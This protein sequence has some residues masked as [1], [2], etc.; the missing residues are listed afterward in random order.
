MENLKPSNANL[1]MNFYS[2]DAK[3]AELPNE[4]QYDFLLERNKNYMH[5]TAL[6]FFGKVIT[7]EELHTRIDE[8]ARALYKKGVREFDI[9]ATSTANTPEAIYL[10]YAIN[11]LGAINTP[12]SPI[13]NEYKTKQ[14]L[15]IVKP[16][17]YVGIE[18]VYGMFKKASEGIN[19]MSL[20]YP[21]VESMD[22][23]LIKIL[24]G[25]KQLAN[26]NR[27]L[28]GDDQLMKIIK[29][30]KDSE[31]VFPEYSKGKLSHIIFTGGSSGTHKGV[32]LDD[33]GLNCVVRALDYV[34]P[35]N[36]GEKFMGNLPQFMAFGKM[37]MHYALCKSMQVDLTLKAMPQ[38]FKEELFRL[39]PQGVFAGPV[40]WEHFVNDVFKEITNEDQKI[41]FSLNNTKDYKEYLEN[42]KDILKKSDK[43]KYDM[44]WLHVAV[45]G[46][47]QLKFLTEKVVTATLNEFNVKDPSIYNGLGMTEMWAPVSVKMGSRSSE[48]TIGPMMP[49]T[50]QMIVDPITYEELGFDEVGLLLVS[51]PGMMQGYYNNPEESSKVFIEKEGTRWLNS[52]DMAKVLPNGELVY[53]DRLKRSFVCGVENVYP[54]QIENMLSEIPEIRESIV[55]KIPNNELQYVP[56]YH[57]SLREK[58]DIEE[59]KRKIDNMIQKT[60]GD[61]NVAR[62]YEFYDEPL[63]RT[64]NGKLDPK[65]LQ[66]K[67]YESMKLKTRKLEN[68]SNQ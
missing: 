45:S 47:E 10:D 54:Q 32:M 23:Q 65:P 62:Y 31:A 68:K 42:L 20:S 56:K 34:L 33:N 26:H 53:I 64:A 66:Q 27:S 52:G 24:Y 9:V 6:T 21:A 8:Y 50:N 2:D 18:D 29:K 51:G 67:D 15:A 55:T 60:L 49:F 46:G 30:W 61:S 16:K 12:I 28:F 38:D 36:P 14:D 22:K 48:G 57:V 11:K 17:M 19:I 63:P 44:S 35:L 59:L 7:Y 41:D 13:N 43:N 37:A 25:V 3:T 58:C 39:K 1:N 40:Q 5:N 4:S